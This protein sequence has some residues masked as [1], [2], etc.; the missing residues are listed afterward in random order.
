MK[1]HHLAIFFTNFNES[2]Q[3][4]IFLLLSGYL[5]NLGKQV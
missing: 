3:D 2:T 1:Y 4:F 5:G